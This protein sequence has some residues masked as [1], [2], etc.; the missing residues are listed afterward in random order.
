ME[1]CTNNI[2]YE[3]GLCKLFKVSIVYNP[4]LLRGCKR[5]VA[6]PMILWKSPKPLNT[7]KVEAWRCAFG[8]K[9]T[10]NGD[11]VG[12]LWQVGSLIKFVRSYCSHIYFIFWDFVGQQFMSPRYTNSSWDFHNISEKR[13]KH[14]MNNSFVAFVCLYILVMTVFDF[15]IAICKLWFPNSYF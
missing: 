14:L 2:I 15:P 1:C 9:I 12:P 3:F 7:L 8:T 10:S 4:W 11:G 5:F 6:A 13:E